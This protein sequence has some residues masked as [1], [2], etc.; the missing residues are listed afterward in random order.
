MLDRP[1]FL[2]LATALTE[3]GARPLTGPALAQRRADLAQAAGVCERPP[4]D[5][6]LAWHEFACSFSDDD[7]LGIYDGEPDLWA[8]AEPAE[9]IA[10]FGRSK[11]LAV[12]HVLEAVPLAVRLQNGSPLL[13]WAT[14]SSPSDPSSSLVLSHH[15]KA[16]SLWLE[17]MTITQWLQSERVAAAQTP[18]NTFR[19]AQQAPPPSAEQPLT[20]RALDAECQFDFELGLSLRRALTGS[21]RPGI[22]LAPDAVGT[23]SG[24]GLARL[25]SAWL[26]QDVERWRQPDR[27]PPFLHA[28]ASYLAATEPPPLAVAKFREYPIRECPNHQSFQAST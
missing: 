19:F 8:V 27:A 18:L 4:S 28:L 9:F 10:A 3:A 12:A 7:A 26:T 2:R 11:L 15:P 17:R 20:D 22:R 21:T 13:A 25:L 16:P 5:E 6:L 14:L 23:S 1:T 24:R